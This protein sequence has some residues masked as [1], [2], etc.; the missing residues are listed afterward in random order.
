[1]DYKAT[2]LILTANSRLALHLQT[3]FD[4]QQ[5]ALGKTSW[6]TQSAI[7]LNRWIEALFHQS[8]D[9]GLLLLTDFQTQCVW[10]EIV[11]Q[12][13]ET[14]TLLQPREMARLA[15]EAY[16]RLTLWQVPLETLCTFNEQ[17]EVA[18]LITWITLF[19]KKLALNEWIITA[20]LPAHLHAKKIALPPKIHLMGFDD[21]SPALQQLLSSATLHYQEP[22]HA[23]KAEKII[24]A[25]TETELRTMALWAKTQLE[26][27]P[28]LSIGCVIPNLSNI[29]N[30]V[31]N[32][33]TE[34]FCIA[35][36]LPGHDASLLPFNI[37]AGAALSEHPMIHTALSVLKWLK[38]AIVIDDLAPLL[39]S[40]YL[41]NTEFD[42]N[43]GA[44]I[45]ALLRKKNNLTVSFK[46]IVAFIP[47]WQA[48]FEKYTDKKSEKLLPSEWTHVF[49]SL[50]KLAHWPASHTQSSLEFQLLERFKKLLTEFSLLDTIFQSITFSKAIS[51]LSNLCGE[52]IFQA[53]SHH[54]P[55]QIMGALEASSISFDAAW[56][57]SMDDVTWPAATK[58]H[59]LIPYSI[60]QQFDMPHATAK[61]ELTFCKHITTRLE[62]CA[63]TVIFS[64]P[65]QEGDQHRSASALIAHLPIIDFLDSN[66]TTSFSEKIKCVQPLET[67]NDQNASAL[68]T[69]THLR[70][71]SKI[72]ELQ[73]LCP[74]RAFATIR[75]NAQPL[76]APALGIPA[77]I[78]GTLV[79]Q[80]L[81]YVWAQLKDQPTLLNTSDEALEKLIQESIDQAFDDLSLLKNN[82]FVAVERKRLLNLIQEWLA[83]EKT[84]P[85]FKVLACESEAKITIGNLPITI[86]QDRVD[87]L[88]DGTRL[89]ID[90]KTKEQTTS[91]WFQERLHNAQLPL[92]AAFNEEKYQ[93][94]CFA[95]ITPKTTSLKGV[96]HEKY[97]HK[98]LIP[99]HRARNANGIQDWDELIHSWK[100]SLEQLSNDFCNGIATVDPMK[101]TVCQTCELQSVCRYK[102]I[103]LENGVDLFTE[104]T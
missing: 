91:G 100:K 12:S 86:R 34:V 8:N 42:K 35:H 96:A 36:I 1:M 29:R 38:K 65:A 93:G 92:Y 68:T 55:I 48:L 37:S 47:Q 45:D 49:I 85:A 69:T 25:D 21:L 10:E 63:K 43:T 51:L 19:E 77:H 101:P 94:I 81:F 41:W 102:A 9:E 83:Y 75:L 98:D 97:A 104:L 3:T 62:K 73:A 30:K 46:S 78:K 31:A 2:D 23:I 103:D 79:H 64:A 6:E 82:Y 57:M 54:E 14:Q 76:Y 33:F 60:Q 56:I 58:P 5:Q 32:I 84:R 13:K 89:L 74:F 95:E 27:N 52:T 70:G 72:L 88:S 18:C 50:L 16:E 24:L 71:G 80:L 59:P 28:L 4:K 53:K 44:K 66:T 67:I 90:Y 20:Q 11:T 26:K 7:P 40:S 87:A 15:K 99:I 22:K 17:V 61:R 39:Q